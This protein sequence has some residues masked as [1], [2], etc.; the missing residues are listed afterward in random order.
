SGWSYRCS[1][2]PTA[3][4]GQGWLPIPFSSNPLI[5]LDRLPIDPINK[6]PYY[7]TFVFTTTP[8][9]QGYELT[10]FKENRNEEIIV[11]NFTSRILSF[12]RQTSGSGQTVGW[13]KTYGR[14]DD[15]YAYSI[16]PTSDGGYIVAGQTTIDGPG[17]D[18]DFLILKLDS[19]G[20]LVWGRTY[21]GNRLD[22][23]Y[24]IS[25]TSDGGYVV[26]GYTISFGSGV[27]FLVLKLD[28]NGNIS[29]CNIIQTPNI[30][31]ST[32]TISSSTPN[33]SSST[34]SISSSTPNLSSSTPSVSSQ[35]ICPN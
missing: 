22:Y 23:A 5:N 34:P 4:N 19:N 11:S 27:D 13:A 21:G 12:N 14:S 6:P 3:M 8:S 30:S 26:A 33:L 31:S 9:R 1:A 7:Y 24:S 15:D 32:P 28:S 35:T 20:N 29:N 17:E 2:T 25:P 10:A 16:S 18:Y